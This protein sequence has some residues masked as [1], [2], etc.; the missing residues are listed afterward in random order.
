MSEQ[1]ALED[2]D[3]FLFSKLQFSLWLV[4][5][6]VKKNAIGS[7]EGLKKNKLFPNNRLKLN[8][9]NHVS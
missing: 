9:P 7:D 6:I 4:E 1:R 8:Q 3:F 5:I 2:N